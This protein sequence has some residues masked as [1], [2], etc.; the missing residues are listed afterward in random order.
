MKG[1]ADLA[2]RK[3]LI[4]Y[5]NFYFQHWLLESR[6][7]Y[8]DFP[9][10]PVNTI[11]QTDLPDE[12]PAA[13][14]FYDVTHPL[15]RELHRAYIRHALDALKDNTNVVHGIDREYTGP[16]AFVRFWLD[17]IA[18]WQQETGRRVFISLEIP[19]A[20]MDE[21]LD[22]PA[23][24]PM[25]TA[26]DVLG[27]TYRADGALFAARGGINRAPREQRPDIATAEELDALKAKIGVAATDQRDFLN[28]PEFQKLVDELWASSKPMRYRAWREYRDGHPR[29]VLLWNGDEYADLTRVIERAVPREARE[30]M[31]PADLVRSHHATTW[32]MAKG[33]EAFLV[34]S[35]NGEAA[36]LDLSGARGTFTVEWLDQERGALQ[37]APAV[38]GGRVRTLA[39]P[40]AGTGG[41]WV[42]WL[43]KK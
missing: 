7:H 22:D 29:L 1:F 39:P 38:A 31:R 25:I 5:H 19:K 40:K 28:G 2:D 9:W 34:Y 4:L 43:K 42:A 16:I 30:G 11:Q 24:G 41:A 21:I 32:C 10:R 12:V 8:V 37:N 6:S 33:T 17:T 3:G 36:V 20:Q 27:W 14:V 18:E 35:M 15:R 13:N 26:A 23:R